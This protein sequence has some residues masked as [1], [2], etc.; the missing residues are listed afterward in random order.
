MTQPF[1]HTTPSELLQET[2]QRQ[3]TLA[4][5][6]RSQRFTLTLPV[7]IDPLLDHPTTH[8]AFDADEYLPYW[9]DLWPSARM[10]GQALLAAPAL[11]HRILEIGCGLGLSGLVALSLG[12]HV[13]FSDYD[14]AA[15]GFAAHNAQQNGFT[16]FE[17]LQMDWRH[18]PDTLQFP[19]ILA[20]DILYE[21]RHVRPVAQLI[22]HGLSPD[23]ECWLVDP[24]RP[25]SK[26][27]CA[28]LTAAGLTFK[29]TS[30]AA[31][32]AD[33]RVTRG[34]LYCIQHGGRVL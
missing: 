28:A 7:D 4:A 8:A 14:A 10:L 25:Y 27:F 16:E 23:G 33:G 18:P 34:T 26:D 31:T 29:A 20:A 15:L 5:G 2:S 22:A 17:I 19:L 9:A 24:N 13:T 30:A 3:V 21:A 11:P 12:S 6:K 1:F 32:T